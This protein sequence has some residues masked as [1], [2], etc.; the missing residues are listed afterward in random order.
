MLAFDT[1]TRQWSEPTTLPTGLNHSQVATYDGKL[2]LAGGYLDGEEPTS[3]RSGS[4]TRGPTAGPSCP[5][6]CQPSA[7]GAVAVIGDKLYVAGGAPQTFDVSWPDQ[8]LQ[9]P[10][11]LRLQ[12]RRM[13][14]RRADAAPA[15]PRRRGGA[16]RQALRGRRTR[17]VGGTEADRSLDI[18]ERYDPA[19]D[20]WESLPNRSRSAPPRSRL[21]AIDGKLVVGRRRGPEQL[22]RRRRL[23]DAQHLGLQPEDATA[24]PASPTCTSNAAA[25]ASRVADGRIYAIGGS[26]CPGLKP[27]GPVGTHTVESLPVSALRRR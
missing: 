13:V 6:C 4:T 23:G 1:R 17:V 14:I 8:P 9:R 21:V 15:P 26:Y 7:A 5:R 2:Y 25:A 16:G 11:D 24:G 27:N 20:S 10:R 19:T 22:G 12:D 18:F 3:E